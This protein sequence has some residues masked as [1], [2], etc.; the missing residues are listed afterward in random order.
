M[1]FQVERLLGGTVV[2]P[3]YKRGKLG[4]VRHAIGEA[5]DAPRKLESGEVRDIANGV[6]YMAARAAGARLPVAPTLHFQLLDTMKNLVP[7]CAVREVDTVDTKLLDDA[8]GPSALELLQGLAASN[9]QDAETAPG[10]GQGQRLKLSTVDYELLEACD[11]GDGD[12]QG[13]R[14]SSAQFHHFQRRK[15]AGC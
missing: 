14:S 8:Q 2:C 10:R 1:L 11:V 12:G 6:G 15:A 4:E 7:L 13:V 9:I 5:E 3:P